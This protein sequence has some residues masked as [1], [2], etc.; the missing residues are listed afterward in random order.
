MTK[1]TRGTT[2]SI[3][4]YALTSFERPDFDTFIVYCDDKSLIHYINSLR[5][6]E[7]NIKTVTDCG[8]YSTATVKL[9][10]I[11]SFNS[12][13]I[14]ATFEIVYEHVDGVNGRELKPKG[15]Y[16]EIC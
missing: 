14:K 13:G 3:N 7:L 5:D 11:N 8:I 4:D 6:L 1:P 10:A 9:S 16:Y 15:G 12:D 2:V